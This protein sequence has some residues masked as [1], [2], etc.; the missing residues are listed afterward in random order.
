M[1]GDAQQPAAGVGSPAW[2]KQQ[3]KAAEDALHSKP[4][5]SRDVQEQMRAIWASGKCTTRDRCAE[6]ECGALSISFFT[7]RKALRNTAAPTG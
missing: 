5:G 1:D 4:G 7:A 6:E 2:R 3:A